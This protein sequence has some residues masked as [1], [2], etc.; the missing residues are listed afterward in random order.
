M[1]FFPW[2]LVAWCQAMARRPAG[3]DRV[4]LLRVTSSQSAAPF[5]NPSIYTPWSA[6]GRRPTVEVTE[7]LPPTQSHIENRASQDPFF[8]ISSSLLPASVTATACFSNARPAFLYASAVSTIPFLVSTV[9]PLFEITRVSVSA[10]SSP[11]SVNRR[12][13]P[14]GSVLSRKQGFILSAGVPRASAMNWGPRADPPMPIINR[15]VKRGRFSG[16]IVPAWTAEAKSFTA[17][18]VASISFRISVEGA[19]SGLRSQ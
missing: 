3:L 4:S 14:L 10:R 16:L 13:K 2:P 15:R 7:V 17:W 1:S 19:R 12:S 5:S 18:M 9:P 11:S 8:A 6:A